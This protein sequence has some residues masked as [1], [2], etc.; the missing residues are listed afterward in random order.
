MPAYFESGFQVGQAA[1]HRL[2]SVFKVG[3][4]PKE[5]REAIVVAGADFLVEP[6]EVFVKGPD[7]SWIEL[8]GFKAICRVDTGECLGVVTNQY[9]PVQN[10]DKFSFFDPW[11]QSG[12]ADYESAG[13]LKGGKI[14]FIQCKINA[15]PF[16]VGKGDEVLP[17]LTLNGGH[18]GGKG[19]HVFYTKIREVCW[20]TVNMAEAA[21][22]DRMIRIHH[23]GDPL[24]ALKLVQE[25][26]RIASRQFEV[27]GEKFRA[28]AGKQIS[29]NGLEQYVRDVLR[30]EEGK[31]MPK[32][33]DRIRAAFE[34]GRGAELPTARG[35]VWGAY[36]AI[37]NWL[38]HTKTVKVESNRLANSWFG[39]GANIRDR[40]FSSAV[41]LLS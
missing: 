5:A 23:R 4:G 30:I 35:T 41:S 17:Y 29:V 28:M 38:D 24:K 11:I 31:D 12:E 19:I 34:Y 14:V 21:V 7:G 26:V 10:V 25:S 40:A 20:N 2:G 3:E 15:D 27:D 6:R 36:N 16:V 8:E 37:T 33:W 22:G 18:G 39:G 1:W 13:V 32:Q 9:V